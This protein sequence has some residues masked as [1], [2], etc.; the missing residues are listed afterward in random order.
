MNKTFDKTAASILFII[1]A[2]FLVES[3]N[4]ADSAYGSNVGPDIFPMGLGIILMLLSARLFYETFRYAGQAKD[5]VTLDYKSFLL[6]LL[7]AVVYALTL[8]TIGYIITTFLFLFISFQV[9]SRGK[10]LK[11]AVIAGVFSYGVYY[12]FVHV[13]KG[14]LPG[15]PV[16]FQ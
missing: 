1:G 6:I 13:L 14:S 3:R 4:I 7:S 12:L 16:W 10:L 15:W 5:K 11:S 8:E 2:G 9:L